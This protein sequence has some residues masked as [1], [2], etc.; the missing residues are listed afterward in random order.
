MKVTPLFQ[1]IN[2]SGFKKISLLRGGSRSSKTYSLAQLFVIWLLTGKFGPHY[3]K[4]DKAYIL[5]KTL[6]ALKRTVLEDFLEVLASTGYAEAV[7]YNKTNIVFTFID[8]DV[9]KRTVYFLPADDSE[10]L[11]GLNPGLVWI[12]EADSVS[13]DAFTQLN[14]RTRLHLVAD[15]NPSNPDSWP[16]TLENEWLEKRKDITLDVSTY[17]DNPFLHPSV[18][19]EI[20]ILKEID[21]ELY[22]VYNLGNWATVSNLVFPRFDMIGAMPTN[23][24]REFFGLDFGFENPS[25][26]VRVVINGVDLFIDELFYRPGMLI[27]EISRELFLNKVDKIH[28]DSASPNLIEELK[29]LG[30]TVK[31]AKKGQDSV[32]Q[33]INKVRQFNIHITERSIN[34]KMEFRRYKWQTDGEGN[35]KTPLKPIDAF[36]HIPDAVRYSIS[37]IMNRKF[38]Y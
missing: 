10:K 34:A 18:I 17:H 9:N 3:Y 11:K 12:N 33:G 37:Y 5:R 7:D 1:R 38:K 19:H 26:C 23:Y 6:P 22:Q 20:E 31:K 15:Y 29:R 2:K 14:I 36:N 16:K 13:Y 30:N 4:Q 24:E 32:R 25:A 8:S 35:L 27:N 28:C 21:V